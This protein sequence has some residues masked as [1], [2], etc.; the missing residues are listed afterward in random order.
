MKYLRFLPILILAALA[1]PAPAEAQV[2][3]TVAVESFRAVEGVQRTRCPNDPTRVAVGES[4]SCKWVAWD[5]GG[6]PTLATFSLTKP[7]W[8][9]GTLT[10]YGDS[11]TATFTVT[12]VGSGNIIL[13][14]D[15]PSP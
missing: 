15:D 1:M 7:G 12:G 13:V 9:Q 4:F 11:A 8:I 5:E 6:F 3:D 2:A 14:A 10:Q